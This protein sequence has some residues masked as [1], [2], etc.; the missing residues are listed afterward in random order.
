MKATVNC[1]QLSVRM[2][3]RGFL[4][5][6]ILFINVLWVWYNTVSWGDVSEKEVHEV[7][8]LPRRLLRRNKDKI[9]G[10]EN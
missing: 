8:Y 5:K 10:A 6:A 4:H 7:D 3:S 2:V 1:F 9:E